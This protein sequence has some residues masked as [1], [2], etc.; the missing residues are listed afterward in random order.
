MTVRKPTEQAILDAAYDLFTR[1]GYHGT[2]MRQ[3][4]E[5]AGI[6]LGG[7]YN[8]FSSKEELFR[9]VF[10]NNHPFLEMI[11]A[12]QEAR[13]ESIEELV[14]HSAE[15]MLDAINRKPG[16]INL[17]FVEIVEFKSIHI[18]EMFLSAFP[19]GLRIV[20]KISHANGKLRDIPAPMMLRSFIG[21]FFSY[22]LA[23]IILR[24]TAPPEFHLNAMQHQVDIFLHGIL[25]E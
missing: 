5:Q 1:Q 12:I 15:L 11:P 10:L 18:H 3:L 2:S 6:A 21:L 17:T 22:Y 9:N 8:H 23:D 4:A 14:R 19:K 24:D 25:E 20:E 16:F 7:I 13:G